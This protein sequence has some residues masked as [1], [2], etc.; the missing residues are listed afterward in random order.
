M[1]GDNVMC[2]LT[3]VVFTQAVGEHV[4]LLRLYIENLRDRLVNKR[5]RT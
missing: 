3:L 5:E 4:F 2:R 1:A